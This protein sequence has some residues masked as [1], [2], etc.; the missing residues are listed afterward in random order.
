MAANLPQHQSAERPST[1]TTTS[2]TMS[3]VSAMSKFDDDPYDFSRFDIKP[4]QKLG[5]RPVVAGDAKKRP[6][7]ASVSSLPATYRPTV[8]RPDVS[9]PKSQGPGTLPVIGLSKGLP[10]PPPIPDAPEYNPRPLSRGSIKSLPSHK[11]TAMTPD[12]IRLMKAV[13]L[14]KK[15]LRK[16]NPQANTFVPPP[17]EVP[18]VLSVPEPAPKQESEAQSSYHV[19]LQP[20]AVLQDEQVSTKKAD[21]GIEMEYDPS[22]RRENEQTTEI[23]Q[24]DTIEEAYPEPTPAEPQQLQTL[25]PQSPRADTPRH[26]VEQTFDDHQVRQDPAKAIVVDQESDRISSPHTSAGLD[27]ASKTNFLPYLEQSEQDDGPALPMSRHALP[28]D[29][30]RGQSIDERRPSKDDVADVPTIIMGDGSRPLSALIREARSEDSTPSDSESESKSEDDSAN[31]SGDLQPPEKHVRR[32][33]SDI[34]KRRRGFVEPLQLD[35]DNDFSSDEDFMDELQTAT[36]QEA[37]PITVARSPV[38]HYFPRRPSANSGISDLDVSSVRTVTMG[39]RVSTSPLD[40]SDAQLRLTPE[41][42][43]TYS[44]T[45]MRST[46]NASTEKAGSMSSM[47]RNISDT[48]SERIQS[49]ATSSSRDNVANDTPSSSRPTSPEETA[50]GYIAKDPRGQARNPPPVNTRTSSFRAISRHSSRISAYQSIM[51][52]NAPQQPDTNTTWNVQNDNTSGVGSVS[53]T[54]R[55]VRPTTAE[56]TSPTPDVESELRPSQL[57]V[58]SHKRGAQSQSSVPQL[59]RIDTNPKLEDSLASSNTSPTM[60]RPSVEGSRQLHSAS[61]FGRHK[62]TSPTIDDFPAPPPR[63]GPQGFQPIAF[64]NEDNAAA[65]ETTRTG[66]FF[67]RMSNIGSNMA[68]K[69]KSTVAQSI[70]SSTSPASERESLIAHNQSFPGSKDRQDLPPALTVGDLNVQFPDSLVRSSPLITLRTAANTP[71][72]WKRRIVE[73]DDAGW[74]SFSI[75]QATGHQ[76]GATKRYQ[77][78]EFRMPYIPDLDRQELPNSIMLDF[79][80]G[81]TL[82]L[83][84]EDSMT[85]RQVT[86]VL[87]SY[88]RAWT[89]A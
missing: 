21:S 8:K 6:A 85:H 67:K 49:F 68:N 24:P 64:N 36:L 32:Q 45:H 1:S 34:A 20:A 80:D 57:V 55:I 59:H 61:K 5:P 27:L 89:A 48:I 39:D 60:T 75:S 10:L 15:Q 88:W 71:Q 56:T 47:R 19:A 62:P 35:G 58:S 37:K 29:S 66:R 82:Q 43:S 76:R 78:S 2:T 87:K 17:E 81:T 31:S 84:C 53:V 14:R 44:P 52:S 11:S 22:I 77:L 23:V 70:A 33:N 18:A 7:V 9:R 12:K 25:E 13:E 40:F 28:V 72:L 54:A 86:N 42:P 3:S 38:A 83:A 79:I 4:K 46:S 50:N 26:V 16:S 41:P 74:I 51:G 73:I 30:S 63:I 69:R 65:K